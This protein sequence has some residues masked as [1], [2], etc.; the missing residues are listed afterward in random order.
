MFFEEKVQGEVS[1]TCEIGQ[2]TRLGADNFP[3][4]MRLNRG[5]SMRHPNNADPIKNILKVIYSSPRRAIFFEFGFAELIVNPNGADRL[6][7][8]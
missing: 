4:C 6:G 3:R 7:L 5:N 2:L 1:S 8:R